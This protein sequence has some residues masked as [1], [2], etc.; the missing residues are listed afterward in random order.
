MKKT[1]SKILIMIVAFIYCF[2]PYTVKRINGECRCGCHE[3]ICYCCRT[4]GHFEDM[5]SFMECGGNNRDESYEQSPAIS[6]PL[7]ELAIVLHQLHNV[8]HSNIDSDLPGYK[9]PPMK[10]P[11]VE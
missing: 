2:T 11:P 4:S 10:P 5:A 3:F 7:F 9:D 6:V 1:T 8:F